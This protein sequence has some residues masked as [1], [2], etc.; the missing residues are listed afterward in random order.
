[1]DEYRQ[2][3]AECPLFEGVAEADVEAL[4]DCAGAREAAFAR[5]E[6]FL[7]K[8]ADRILPEK[9]PLS[10]PKASSKNAA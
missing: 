7:R 1:M 5:E 2:I 3:L 10:T 4:L 6:S 9:S 8:R